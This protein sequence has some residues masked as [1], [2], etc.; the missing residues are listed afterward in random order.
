MAPS[1]TAEVTACDSQGQVTKGIVA[2]ALLSLR[3]LTLGE[4]T[5]H[6]IRTPK[7]HY[8]DVHTGELRPAD[9]NDLSHLG[10]GS[11]SLSQ[12]FR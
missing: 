7:Q 6:V 3:F 4:S 10:S 2:S 12:A 9:N 1:N 5:S 11:S 8:G